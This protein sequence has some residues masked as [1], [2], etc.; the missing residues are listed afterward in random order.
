MSRKSTSCPP[1]QDP[2]THTHT[3]THTNPQRHH[4]SPQQQ[5]QWQQKEARHQHKATSSR[6]PPPL[7]PAS[8]F[9]PFPDAAQHKMVFQ[10]LGGLSLASSVGAGAFGAH[11]LMSSLQQRGVAPASATASPADVWWRYWQQ[12]RN[13][14]PPPPPPPSPTEVWSRAVHYQQLHSVGL[15]LTPVL[16]QPG[17]LARVLAGTSFSAGLLLFSGG[18]YASTYTGDKQ[19]A[20]GAPFGGIAFMVGWVALAAAGRGK[21]AKTAVKAATAAAGGARPGL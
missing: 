3:H 11:G 8:P 6:L 14:G 10:A 9:L 12:Q 17:S 5:Q 16:T 15:L 4:N 13:G 21:G 7:L 2:P 1:F 20:K 18:L 19:L